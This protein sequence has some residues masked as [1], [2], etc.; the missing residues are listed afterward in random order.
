MGILIKGGRVIDPDTK[1]DGVA[2]VFIED[3]VIQKVGKIEQ[4]EAD[5]VLDASGCYVMPGLIDLHVHFR[6]P[7]QEEKEDIVSGGKAAAKGGFTTVM[8]MPNTHPVIDTASRVNYVHHKAE[9]LCPIRVLQA[10]AITKGQKGEELSDIEEMIQAG[11]PA[12]SEDGKSVMNSQLYREAMKVA[13]RHNIPVMAHC[14]DGPMTGNGCMNEDEKAKELK[15]PGIGNVVEDIIVA[16]D[17]FLSQDTGAHLHLCHCSTKQSMRMLKMAK[18]QG[19]SV[20]GEVCPHHF[21]LCSE[22]IPGDNPNFKM[23][24]PLRRRE[25]KEEILKAFK[26][27]VVDVISTDHAP[28]TA[29]EKSGSMR[30]APFGI[31]GLETSVALTITELVDKGIIT[32]MQMAMLMSYNPAQIIHLDRGSLREGKVADIVIIDPEEA[33]VID[34]RTFVSKGKN[35]PFHGKKVKGRVKATIF[36]GELVYQDEQ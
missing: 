6:D 13:R 19:M 4:G 27:G 29:K 16:R 5:Q 9:E 36:E 3:G 1:L 18:E 30:D 33:Y 25:D 2:D 31:V 20:T 12:I 17:I 26:E 32:P 8:A 22:D 15:L 21:T 14:E 23:N 24:P 10:G 35:T 34:S 7:G 11:I 28:H